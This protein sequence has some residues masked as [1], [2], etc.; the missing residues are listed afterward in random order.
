MGIKFLNKYLI[1]KCSKRSI[2]RVNLSD[3]KNKVFVIDTSIYLY[4]FLGENALIENMY[5]FLS[6]MHHNNI[7]PIF[8]FDGKPPD[9]KKELLR[10]R[11]LEKK[12]AESKYDGIKQQIIDASYQNITI[13]NRKEL[14]D[15]MEELRQKFIR[16]KDVDIRKVKELFDAFGASYVNSPTE[17][18][19]LCSY[20]SQGENVYCVSDDMDMFIYGCKNIVRNIDLQDDSLLLYSYEN[21]LSDLNMTN[22]ELKEIL[23]LSGTDYNIDLN[24]S[25]SETLKWFS[26]YKKEVA[27]KEIEIDF[28]DWLIK[29]TKYVEDL[30]KLNKLYAYFSKE[31]LLA[32]D[33][34]IEVPKQKEKNEKKIQ[35]IMREEG[36]VFLK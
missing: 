13:E 24:T 2:R 9:E 27:K 18:D 35:E 7:K 11:R 5:L 8:I 23:I 28:Y 12:E 17:A 1:K 30:D 26:S 20:L 21:I 25:L 33:N 16:V 6:K 4:K 3:L 10:Q 32:F 36:F 19:H 29:N 14:L 34:N 22:K 31:Y 15:E